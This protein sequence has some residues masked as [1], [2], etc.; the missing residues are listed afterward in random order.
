MKPEQTGEDKNDINDLLQ[1]ANLQTWSQRVPEKLVKKA[2]EEL[3]KT[4]VQNSEQSISELESSDQAYKKDIEMLEASIGKVA[5]DVEA[6]EEGEKEEKE[7]KDEK[8]DDDKKDKKDK[9]EDAKDDDKKDD[10]KPSKKEDIKEKMKKMREKRKM[11]APKEDEGKDK[12]VDTEGVEDKPALP[13]EPKGKEEGPAMPP[14]PAMAKKDLTATFTRTATKANS[15]WEVSD[16]DGEVVLAFTGADA[17][18]KK[19]FANWN[20]FSTKA[21]GKALLDKIREK[22]FVA[23]AE[24]FAM[25]PNMT[26][27]ACAIERFAKG[28]DD[29]KEMKEKKEKAKKEK[30]EKEAQEKKEKEEKK[31][32]K[33][34][35]LRRKAA[36]K[37]RGKTPPKTYFQQYFGKGDSDAKAYGRDLSGKVD[38]NVVSENKK[39]K[40]IV[41]DLETKNEKLIQS[42]NGLVDEKKLRARAEKALILVNAMVDKKIIKAEDRETTVEKLTI[43]DDLSYQMMNDFVNKAQA[44]K[45]VDEALVKNAKNGKVV[46]GL[47][48]LLVQTSNVEGFRGKLSDMLMNRP[49]YAKLIE[50]KNK[51]LI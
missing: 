43:M 44:G 28:D 2:M 10:K 14:V 7:E 31:K 42:N 19:I 41:A 48:N 40:K 24:L 9:K 47:K 49:K 16:N 45:E 11:K 26:K 22:G 29:K 4:Q 35:F 5:M 38:L 37:K 32:N 25:E 15:Y 3:D 13:A 23:V 6:P 8:K 34:A 18:G 51:K 1:K 39:L 50:F 36:P 17:F 30:E 46:S 33:K 12:D 27:H 21:Y 20:S